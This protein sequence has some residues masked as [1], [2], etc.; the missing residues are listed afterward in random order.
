MTTSQLL[1]KTLQ[2]QM[3]ELH[4]K[5]A[6]LTGENVQVSQHVPT[7]TDYYIDHE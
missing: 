2:A 4:S 5:I 7:S 6:T 3:Q 1:L